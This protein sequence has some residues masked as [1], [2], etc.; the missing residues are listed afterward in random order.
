MNRPSHLRRLRLGHFNTLG[1][2]YMYAIVGAFGGYSWMLLF[3]Q[4]PA[5]FRSCQCQKVS[6]EVRNPLGVPSVSKS[7]SE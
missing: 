1:S 3:A 7:E 5:V 4:I 2:L 6:N